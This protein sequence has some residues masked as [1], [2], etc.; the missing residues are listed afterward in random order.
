MTLE[1]TYTLQEACAYL[2]GVSEYWLK[3]TAK[4]LRIGTRMAKKLVFTEAH[5]KQLL[6]AHDLEAQQ[7]RARRTTPQAASRT[8]PRAAKPK[9]KPL[10]AADS[11]ATALRARPE[12]AR[13][14]GT[15]AS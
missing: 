2:G 13:S 1:K 15:S 12:R 7:P 14:Y 9:P 4:R 5:L 11:A 8:T 6:A 3:R 10:P